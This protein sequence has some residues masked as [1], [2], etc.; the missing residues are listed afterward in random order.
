[1]R[2]RLP[3]ESIVADAALLT[4]SLCAIGLF[5]GNMTVNEVNKLS[6]AMH[7]ADP[8]WIPDPLPAGGAPASARSLFHLLV[9]PLLV[10]LGFLAASIVGRLCAYLLLAFSLAS[11]GRSLGLRLPFLLGA[12]LLFERGQSI[13]AGEWILPTLGPK[14]FSYGLVLLALGQ[15]LG[16]KRSAVHLAWMLGLATSFH[17][18]VGLYGAF[19]IVGTLLLERR[20]PL[21]SLREVALAAA[22]FLTCGA[23]AWPAVT[24]QLLGSGAPS[25]ASALL[26]SSFV[27]VFLRVPHHLSPADWPEGWWLRAAALLL[28]FFASH[29]FLRRQRMRLPLRSL[30]LFLGLAMLPFALGLAAAPFDAEGR[31]LQF[32]LFRFGDT[33]LPLCAALLGA[34]ALQAAAF[35]RLPRI[36]PATAWVAALALLIAG[37]WQL[38][39]QLRMLESFPGPAQHLSPAWVEL[40]SWARDSTDPDA[41]FVH[42][43]DRTES[44]AWLSRRRS[45][46]NFKQI[47]ASGGTSE[48]KRRMD[49]LGAV[50]GP[51]PVGGFA[52]ARWLSQRYRALDTDGVEALMERFDADYFVTVAAHRLELPLAFENSRHAV[53]ARALR[54]TPDLA[55]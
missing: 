18:L 26:P 46:A 5:R 14:V 6:V 11:V 34:R 12:V 9:G 48:W 32:Y 20:P 29:E 54:G 19:A 35:A 8:G 27:Y 42:D 43:P 7:L 22:L 17:P 30:S 28:V 36:A 23:F 21:P 52:A 38:P 47:T 16:P 3:A 39:R 41:L 2:R 25:G 37:A 24:S 55:P 53:Y 40:C 44:F 33:M 45:L 15:L 13:V 1:M 50:E 4:L 10:Q 51:W 31:L 49:A